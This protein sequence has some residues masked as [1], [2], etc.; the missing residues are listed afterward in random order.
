MS[1]PSEVNLIF[2]NKYATEI[3]I[4]FDDSN[5]YTVSYNIL[6][7]GTKQLLRFNGIQVNRLVEVKYTKVVDNL[8]A[9][10]DL[11]ILP[12]DY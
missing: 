3:P 4:P 7:F 9:D 12:E 6:R 5:K 1:K 11:C 2:Q 10:A 8:S